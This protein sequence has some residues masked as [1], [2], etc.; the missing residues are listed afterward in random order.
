MGLKGVSKGL[1]RIIRGFKRVIKDW[2]GSIGVS[3]G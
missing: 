1:N 2:I 3:N